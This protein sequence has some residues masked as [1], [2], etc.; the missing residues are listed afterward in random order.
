MATLMVS[1]DRAS[2]ERRFFTGMALA[3]LVTVIVGF[4][5]SFFLRPLFPDWPSP[6]ETIFYVHGAVFSAWIVLLVVQATLV[7]GSRTELHRR[8]GPFGAVLA[9]AMVVLGTIGALVAARRVTGFT[10]VPVPPLQ[11]LAIPLFDMVLFAAFVSL[12]IA[13][14]RKPQAH[15]R[16]ML[17]A[18]VN[19]VT[20]AIARWPGVFALGPLAFFA[21]TDL[22]VIA[23][24]VWDFRTRG[25][26]HPV[27]LW[28]GL[29]TIVSQPLRLVVSSTEGWLAFARWATGLLA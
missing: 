18:T 10:Q 14:R 29:L 13:N 17:L 2:S 20:A 3:L 8:I 28:G 9:V 19:L 16:W 21:L 5:R 1:S 22:F 15:K 4:S 27:T 7:A 23:L 11:F 24:A 12:A 6:S 26:L 25:R